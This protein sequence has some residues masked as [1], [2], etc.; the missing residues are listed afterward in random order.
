MAA[1]ANPIKVHFAGAVYSLPR[2][3][4][5]V[6][7]HSNLR[8][9]LLRGQPGSLALQDAAGRVLPDGDDEAF[10]VAVRRDALLLCFALPP[11]GDASGGA[12]AA[13]G[14]PRLQAPVQLEVDITPSTSVLTDSGTD[15]D[16][17]SAL[18]ELVDNAISATAANA[19]EG[20]ARRVE[21]TARRAPRDP[22]SPDAED[23][24][25]SRRPSALVVEDN[26]C[27]MS[28]DELRAWATLGVE[29]RA[30]R[31]DAD[32]AAAS[33]AV[34]AARD[35]EAAARAAARAPAEAAEADALWAAADDDA[36]CER[37]ADGTFSRYGMGSKVAVFQIAGAV[38]VV[39]RAAGARLVYEAAL[40]RRTLDARARG[41]GGTA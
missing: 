28:F 37:Y 17:P 40:S 39:T 16:M 41:G 22:R 1:H 27:G 7:F 9:R 36:R 15:Y 19:A 2:V 23:D 24:F 4:S 3:E 25:V 38:R 21:I 32:A 31:S 5:R 26:G 14:P 33:R 34:C 6:A 30:A 20:R 12:G 10:R 11:A 8:A 18:A 13:R 29:R 35:G